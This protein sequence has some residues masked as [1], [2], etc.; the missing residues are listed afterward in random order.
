LPTY[1]I[2]FKTFW[3]TY[4]CNKPGPTRATFLQKF[5]FFETIKAAMHWHQAIKLYQHA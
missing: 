3:A 4:H 1:Q 2:N 5:H